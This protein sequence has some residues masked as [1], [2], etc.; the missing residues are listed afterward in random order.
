MNHQLVASVTTIGLCL[1]S[2]APLGRSSNV[3]RGN[4]MTTCIGMRF[5]RIEAGVFALGTPDHRTWEHPHVVRLTHDYW[6]AET[7]VTQKQ[8]V[9]LMQTRPWGEG[10]QSG[11]A[12]PAVGMSWHEACDFCKELS[13]R[14]GLLGSI[15][16]GYVI[17]LPS[18][19][20]WEIACR[21]GSAD[22]FCF[23]NNVGGLSDYAVW[24]GSSRDGRAEHVKS[25]HPNAFGAYDMHGNV[26]EWCAD[27]F[28]DTPASAIDP[29]EEVGDLR[30]IRGGG[31]S[32]EARY[33]RSA[34]RDCQT[35]TRARAYIGF[36]PALVRR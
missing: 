4:S 36:R 33:C 35:A 13:R 16:N 34:S 11:D 19:A 26:W 28:V 17:A 27:A 12:Y 7:E 1:L 8:W 9:D 15:P 25:R 21:A 5:V 6:I 20:Q 3:R 31:A 29:L 23:G 10:V 22:D 30:A 18:E 14:E 2:C 32:W 24:R